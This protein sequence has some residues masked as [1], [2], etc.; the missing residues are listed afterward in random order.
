[1]GIHS[2][3]PDNLP[4]LLHGHTHRGGGFTG[5]SG[6]STIEEFREK[7]ES[8]VGVRLISADSYGF[9]RVPSIQDSPLI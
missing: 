4:P 9:G 6:F 7:A 8:L 3:L 2:E 1:M 5:V